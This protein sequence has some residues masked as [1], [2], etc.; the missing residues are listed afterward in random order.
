MSA[1]KNTDFVYNFRSV[2]NLLSKPRRDD[3][4]NLGQVSY[5]LSRNANFLVLPMAT[6]TEKTNNDLTY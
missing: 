2:L 3:A 1:V 4:G 6:L 5:Q